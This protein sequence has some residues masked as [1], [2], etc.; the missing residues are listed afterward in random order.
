MDDYRFVCEGTKV[1]RALERHVNSGGVQE[2]PD[3]QDVMQAVK[4]YL[5]NDQGSKL[6]TQMAE[7]D[8]IA[9]LSVFR[10]AW[11]SSLPELPPQ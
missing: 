7:E 8:K 11:D 9:A 4:L 6:L 10:E 3:Y 1:F 2:G 5:L